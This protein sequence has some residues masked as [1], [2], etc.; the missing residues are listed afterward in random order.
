[1][2]IK[3]KLDVPEEPISIVSP[4]E[5]IPESKKDR[6]YFENAARYYAT[7]YNVPSYGFDTGN[8]NSG[9]DL[10]NWDM[11]LS[12]DMV[13][14]FSYLFGRQ[15]NINYKYLTQDISGQTYQS[16]WI[17]GRNAGKIVDFANGDMLSALSS[18]IFDA[19]SL[20]KEVVAK[21]NELFD[22]INL[23]FEAKDSLSGL[24][25]MGVAFKPYHKDFDMKEDID[26]EKKNYKDD[27]ED[28]AIE[29]T[30]DIFKRE[31]C[32]FAYSKAWL[33]NLCGIASI[34]NYV[35]NGKLKKRVIPCFSTIWDNR[36]D[37]D[38]GQGMKFWGFVEYDTPTGWISKYP[39]LSEMGNAVK[40]LQAIGD[41]EVENLAAFTNYY[42]QPFQSN[43]LQW[44]VSNQGRNLIAG[45]TLFWVAPRDL[46]FK[47]GDGKDYVKSIKDDEKF[48]Q[49][50][51]D[52]L[53]LDI[54]K[55]TLI[56]NKWGVDFGYAKNTVRDFYNKGNPVPNMS[57]FIPNMTMGMPR[58]IM[59]MIKKN[60]DEIDRLSH[61]IREITGRDYGRVPVINASVMG[62]GGKSAI[63]FADDIKN[64]GV[65][66]VRTSGEM[67][68]MARDMK[69]VELVDL[70]SNSSILSYLQLKQ[71]EE[72][73][74]E[75]IVG[76]SKA[77]MGQQKQ[78]IS[79]QVQSQSSAL[80]GNVMKY[81]MDG[82]FE[83]IRRDLQYSM[84]VQK[85]LIGSGKDKDGDMIVGDKGVRLIKDLGL[86]RFED[87]Q[88]YIKIE[89]AVDEKDRQMIL[90]LAQAAIQNS[91]QTGVDIDDMLMLINEKSLGQM[92]RKLKNS[93]KKKKMEAEKKA[94]Y[95]QMI[96]MA[97]QAQDQ[98]HQKELAQ[99]QEENKNQ[100]DQAGNETK[101]ASSMLNHSAQVSQANGGQP[102]A[103][104]Q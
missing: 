6:E 4:S 62:E 48:Q 44:Y 11:R 93:M 83:F 26:E 80:G 2:D 32:K 14:N 54:H 63:E 94:K 74:M 10:S 43:N 81:Q 36:K 53:T 78:Y 88:L 77:A 67:M 99:M 7:Y 30:E 87:M 29:I 34:Y 103:T 82:F 59:S 38:F 27:L 22:K 31:N 102:T 21:K 64:V 13:N 9:S 45:V 49:E 65:L 28:I 101:L 52:Y 35:V 3:I 84:N 55:C 18:V 90:S 16:V 97:Q 39:E 70:S 47:K 56:G 23:A 5:L 8:T 69:A 66:V 72:R 33:H 89:D 104:P 100:R 57:F 60:Q 98:Q 20:S 92:I 91:A 71:E 41:N 73:L 19:N 37:D 50:R 46:Q 42:N 76:L 86:R 40:D 79:G 85:M 51:G 12:D 96:Q 61:K 68:Q 17:N 75:E 25:Q 95:E 24:E 1:M 58:P 15:P